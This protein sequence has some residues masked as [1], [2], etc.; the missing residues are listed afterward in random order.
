[1]PIA[2]RWSVVQALS[3]EIYPTCLSLKEH[4][5]SVGSCT[6]SPVIPVSIFLQNTK[7]CGRFCQYFKISV[8]SGLSILLG[9]NCV[10]VMDTQV[11]CAVVTLVISNVLKKLSCLLL[12]YIKAGKPLSRNGCRRVCILDKVMYLTGRCIYVRRPMFK[13]IFL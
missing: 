2:C 10:G 5:G 9:Y 7:L 12:V 11:Q 6:T 4:L 3:E 1:M 13:A 8:S